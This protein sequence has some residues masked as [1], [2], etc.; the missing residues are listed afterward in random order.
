MHI[1]SISFKW[2]IDL[3]FDDMS[4]AFAQVGLS[5]DIK[6]RHNLS[7]RYGDHTFQI[8]YRPRLS[9]AD[10]SY[11][12]LHWFNSVGAVDQEALGRPL[13]EWYFTMSN[14]ANTL[15][16][17][18]QAIV[19]VDEFRPLYGYNE[20]SPKIWSKKDQHHRYS[21]YPIKNQYY[22]EVC[23]RDDRKSVK[24]QRYS[25]WLDEIKHNLLGHE[26]PNDQIAF[27]LT[28]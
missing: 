18:L 15:V 14:Y 3:P 10:R 19:A 17:W 16:Y 9:T 20:T 8:E 6:N 28:G 26:R 4:T 12:W 5:P 24:H 2:S 7:R 1:Q 13:S 27:D 23:N 11:F 22:F 25:F 21:F